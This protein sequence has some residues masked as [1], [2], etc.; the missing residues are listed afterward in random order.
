MD[1]ELREVEQRRCVH[2]PFCI[3]EDNRGPTNRHP[4][5]D[6]RSVECSGLVHACLLLQVSTS[7]LFETPY[8]DHLQRGADLVLL[9]HAAGKC[10][11]TPSM[12]PLGCEPK[13][14]ALLYAAQADNGKFLDFFVA[15]AAV[16]NEKLPHFLVTSEWLVA[17]RK[18][19]SSNW[20]YPACGR[21]TPAEV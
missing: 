16:I 4:P 12:R 8:L 13:C 11:S 14:V 5:L 6:S 2:L 18:D 1:G 21:Q 20:V 7:D 15:I 17:T 3:A 10:L 19:E 9:A